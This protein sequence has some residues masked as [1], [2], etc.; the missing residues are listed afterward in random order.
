MEEKVV[1]GFR[2]CVSTEIINGFIRNPNINLNFMQ[3]IFAPGCALMLYKPYL[4]DKLYAILNQS[5]GKI[6]VLNTR[7]GH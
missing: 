5:I 1:V 7:E 3:K 2:E 6:D 4:A